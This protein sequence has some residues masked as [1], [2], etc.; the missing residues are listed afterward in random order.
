MALVTASRTSPPSRPTSPESTDQKGESAQGAYT[1]ER[2]TS[3]RAHLDVAP[4]RE[5]AQRAADNIERVIVG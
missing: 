1:H 4:I 3:V 2:M 5:L